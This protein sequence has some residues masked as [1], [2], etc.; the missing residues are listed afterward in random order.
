MCGIFGAKKFT[1]FEEL[2]DKNKERGNFSH[3]FFFTKPDGSMF[4]RK[5][6]GEYSTEDERVWGH[7]A[8]Y[9]TFLG[10][11]QAPTSSTRN[12]KPT[13]SH[14]FEYGSFIVAHNGVLENYDDIVD[15][16]LVGHINAVDSS[17]IPA[18]ISFLFEF[19]EPQSATDKLV[20]SN[21]TEEV[22]AIEGACNTIKGTFAC[23]IYSKLTGCTYLVRSGSTLF[24]NIETGDFSSIRVP[25]VCDEE[26]A[27]GTV[28]CV[29]PEGLATCGRF[30]SSSPFFI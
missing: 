30:D 23:W 29:T 9:S 22:L 14:P 28:Y 24:A 6:S 12:F 21:K 1:Q 20:N 16:I 17:L 27:E 19:P 8:E 3:G 2:Y 15:D 4:I 25:G 26:L 7:D 13:T 11:T 18:L 5:G 10:H